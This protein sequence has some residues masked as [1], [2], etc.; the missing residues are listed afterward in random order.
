MFLYAGCSA[1]RESMKFSR[2]IAFAAILAFSSI[3]SG[4]V[5]NYGDFDGANVTFVDVTEVS[6]ETGALYGAPDVVNDTLDFPATGFLSESTNGEIDF[7][8]GRLTFMVEADPGQTLNSITLEEF[9]AYFT[10]GED[11]IAS[12]SAVAFVETLEGGLF[13]DGFLF[14][15]NGL[16]SGP[17][18]GGWVESLTISF[19]ATTKITVTLDNQLFT[20]A[21]DPGVS[22]IDKGGVN[23]SVGVVVPEPTTS[24]LFILGFAGMAYRRRR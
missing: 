15:T 24:A 10:F 1:E 8:D 12:V 2:L 14:E 22:F 18:S 11:S 13:Q 6:L 23:I 4:D 20:F 16:A 3:A 9:G 21:D 17:D 5:I 19:P 7:L